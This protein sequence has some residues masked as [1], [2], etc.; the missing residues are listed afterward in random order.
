MKSVK[1]RVDLLITIN[2]T[3]PNFPL[4]YGTCSHYLCHR[5]P[6]NQPMV[7]LYHEKSKNFFLTPESADKPIIMIGPGTGIA[8]F[9]GFMQERSCP[10]NWIFF[11]ERRQAYDFYYQ[12]EWQ[13][14]IDQ[15][16]L[17]L[18]TAFSRDGD[19]K[20]YV[21]HKM[22]K[23]QKEIW[24]WLEQGAYIFV[25]GDAKVMAKDVDNALKQIISSNSSHDPKTYIK[26]LRLQKRY[27]R[28]VY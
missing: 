13:T 10:K 17:R 20:V 24:Q 26:N 25:C 9:R 2:E 23:Y 6:I 4:P 12:E 14:Y 18:T 5:A 3:P 28:D 1:K 16:K 11:G 8:P 15:G 27:Q 19:K 7:S 21:Q 22:L